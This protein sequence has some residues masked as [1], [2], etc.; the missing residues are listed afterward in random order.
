M[1]FSQ[2]RDLEINLYEKVLFFIQ[3]KNRDGIWFDVEG[4]E[5]EGIF[6]RLVENDGIG[7]LIRCQL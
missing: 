5:V 7:D 4:K 3:I 1:V 6:L 2:R